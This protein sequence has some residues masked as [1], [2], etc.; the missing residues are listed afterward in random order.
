MIS[1]TEAAKIKE[2][3]E[4]NNFFLPIPPAPAQEY[5][6]TSSVQK[7][8]FIH[9]QFEGIG[10]SYNIT[11]YMRINGKLDVKRLETAC[12]RL[13]ER[14][15]SLRTSFAVKN[16]E[17]VQIIREKVDFTIGYHELATGDENEARRIC[18]DMI[19]PFD[20]NQAPLLRVG[21][22]KL[23][24]AKYL[25]LFDIHHIIADGASIS[26]L[27]NELYGLYTEQ[28]LPELTIQYKDFAVW[29]NEL[30]GTK[31]LQEQK[32]Y[33]RNLFADEIPLFNLPLDYVRKEK[34]TFAGDMVPYPV[35]SELTAWILQ[36]AKKQRI[37]LN[38]LSM[39]VYFLLLSKYTNQSDLVIG[40]IVSGRRHPDLLRI[41][42]MFVNSLPV[43]IKIRDNDSFLAFLQNAAAQISKA[44]KNQDYPYEKIIEMLPAHGD[45]S[46]NPL[47]DTMFTFSSQSA[48]N[49]DW[50]GEGLSF[51]QYETGNNNAKFDLTFNGYINPGHR[52]YYMMEYNSDLFKKST[53]ERMAEHFHNILAIVMENPEMQLAEIEILSRE[54]RTRILLD[55]NDTRVDYPEGLTLQQLFEAQVERNPEQIALIFENRQLTYRELN[56]CSNQLARVL[57]K[58]GIKP[59]DIVGIM[60]GRSLEMIMGIIAILKAGGAY[61]PI[62]PEYPGDRINSMLENANPKL[63]L[64]TG[65]ID[66]KFSFPGEVILLETQSWNDYDSSN[67]ELINRPGDLAYVIYTSGSTSQPKGVMIEHAGISNTIQWRRNEYGLD[68]HDTVLQL[69]SFAFDGFLT[70]LFT[71]LVSGATV[72]LPNKMEAMDASAI[73]NYIVKYQVTHFIIVP[74]LYSVILQYMTV[75]D[76]KSLKIITLAGEKATSQLISESQEKNPHLELANEYG[77]TENTVATTILRKMNPA[78]NGIIGKPISNTRVYILAPHGKLQ[79]IGVPGE[80]CISGVGLARGYLGSP[81][82]TREKFMDSRIQIPD[83]RLNQSNSDSYL[84]NLNL[85][86]E[87]MNMESHFKMY[88][89]GDLARWLPDGNIEFLGRIDYQVKI[90]GYRVE[91]SEIESR[92]LKHESIREVVVI[93]KEDNTGNKCLFAYI[94]A[95]KELTIGEL[96]RFLGQDLPDYMVPSYFVMLDK[97]PL[98]PGG[99]IDRK[100]LPESDGM[101]NTGME[102]SAP[103]NEHEA[104]LAIIWREILK[105][106]Q[107]G[108]N[109]N[110]FN[111]GGHSLNAIQIVEKAKQQG[112]NISVTDIF[113]LKTIAKI[114]A[115]IDRPIRSNSTLP[116]TVEPSDS[117]PEKPNILFYALKESFRYEIDENETKVLQVRLHNEITTFLHHALSLAVVLADERLLPWYYEHYINIYSNTNE[118]GLLNLEFLEYY[119]PYNGVMYCY[120]LGYN[121]LKEISNI[122]DFII[123]QINRGYYVVINVDEYYLPEKIRYHNDHYVHQSLI[124]GYDNT[125]QK[126]MALG[127]NQENLFSKHTLDY[128]QFMEA[129]E[130]GKLYYKETAPWTEN[131][132]IELIKFKDHLTEYPFDLQR[133][134]TKLD[135]YLSSSGDDPIIFTYMLNKA[136]VKY[137]LNV[138][139][140]VIHHLEN[141]LKGRFTIDYKNIHL[142]AEHKKGIFKRLQYILSRYQLTGDIVNMTECYSQIVEQVEAVRIK[143]L[144]LSY[145]KD[146]LDFDDFPNIIKNTCEMFQSMK[147]QERMLLQAI[148]KQLHRVISKVQ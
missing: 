86:S 53:I 109:D 56:R 12:Q 67:L 99:K 46:R 65:N 6:V 80:L 106:E 72:V 26:I 40:T 51:N 5:Y 39:A 84:G 144:E 31:M 58:R 47:F 122:I 8:I 62:D 132:A 76:L 64:V 92:L 4:P 105:K 35:S 117:G 75:E 126:L 145:S 127:F 29:Q 77:P 118:S 10:T 30:F 82:L 71:P 16:G 27:I 112:I 54:E 123:D 34:P 146:S 96:R 36:F 22:V 131:S 114:C 11:L 21:L 63:L 139:D 143:Y 19:Q 23:N 101:M 111:L 103:T 50:A 107:V 85:Q 95:E 9:S 130:K 89:T 25:F 2:R 20:L 141:L 104:K 41:I 1:H 93:A 68:N 116:I 134:L 42:G 33:W 44:Y 45:R 120:Y 83:S 18:Q 73:K 102:Y 115:N 60:A 88:K 125:R 108:V 137:G 13:I 97:M 17:I 91:L 7:R 124:Y 133:F 100:A 57:R 90:R 49:L 70:S 14:H 15:E 87:I 61:L 3:P 148:S 52:M 78:L 129:F 138:Y 110:F 37:T 136:N 55:F 147:E 79:P 98:T 28:R 113:S 69:F 121:L 128:N 94:V 32:D 66:Y 59:D 135:N 43:R 119:G 74:S 142:L 140:E 38:V 48:M 81:E 24:D